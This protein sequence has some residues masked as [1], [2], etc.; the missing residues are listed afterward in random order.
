MDHLIASTHLYYTASSEQA[1]SSNLAKSPYLVNSSQK[2][3]PSISAVSSQQR[4][5]TDKGSRLG[6]KKL[7][8]GPIPKNPT[9]S[10]SE[11]QR[12]IGE[13]KTKPGKQRVVWPTEQAQ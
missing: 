13:W 1:A 6:E 8:T 5:S 2:T 7:V 10:A 11:K 4:K 3:G 9:Q 12:K